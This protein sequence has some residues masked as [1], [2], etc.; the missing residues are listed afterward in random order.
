ML[1]LSTL[2]CNEQ[3]IPY[4]NHK[5]QR[6]TSLAA[7]DPPDTFPDQVASES[8]KIKIPFKCTFRCNNVGK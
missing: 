5:Q 3:K 4:L 8:D 6:Q 2:H 7:K 1:L